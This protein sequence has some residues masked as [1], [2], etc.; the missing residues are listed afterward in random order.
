MTTIKSLNEIKNTSG[1]VYVRWSK[2]I[3]LDNKRGY[4]LKYGTSAEAGLSA[5]EIDKT[6][7]DWRIL[8]QIAEYSFC[9]GYAWI[10]TGNEVGTG[11]DNEPLLKN[12]KLIGKVANSL[13]SVD[14]KSMKR[15]AEID[16]C[17]KQLSRTTNE[18][19][20]QII[21]KSL[22]KLLEAK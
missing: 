14:W 18:I 4:S 9:G 17:R 12:V 3:N 16:E 10:V 15:D 6:W 8:R 22:E 21:K 7:E 19:G 20:I 11:E 13:L 5:C 1:R 2:S